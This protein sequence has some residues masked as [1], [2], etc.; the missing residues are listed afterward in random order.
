MGKTWWNKDT[1]N[2]IFNR[3]QSDNNNNSQEYTRFETVSQPSLVTFIS[4]LHCGQRKN[5]VKRKKNHST[6]AIF[7]EI[8]SF[9]SNQ[10]AHLNTHEI[11][12]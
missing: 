5:S 9:Q 7:T 1:N 4:P 11:V 3:V 2:I 10:S 12:K 6:L 8:H